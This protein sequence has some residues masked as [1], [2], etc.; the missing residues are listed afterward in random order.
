MWEC[1]HAV[2]LA[3]EGVKRMPQELHGLL[4]V[5]RCHAQHGDGKDIGRHIISCPGEHGKHLL[6]DLLM[7]GLRCQVKVNVVQVISCRLCWLLLLLSLWLARLLLPALLGPLLPCY[8]RVSLRLLM[9]VAPLGTLRINLLLQSPLLLCMHTVPGCGIPL[10]IFI[11]RQEVVKGV[12]VKC[13]CQS[14][15]VHLGCHN[16][17][18]NHVAAIVRNKHAVLVILSRHHPG[19]CKRLLWPAALR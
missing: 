4:L 1:D 9:C 13:I 18:P 14:A 19:E 7:G 10:L 15:G 8:H 3:G 11:R 12:K 5:P 16:H 6:P 2:V 17:E